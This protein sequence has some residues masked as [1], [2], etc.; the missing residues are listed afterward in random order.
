MRLKIVIPMIVALA[1]LGGCSKASA[2]APATQQQAT[3]T[4]KDGSTFSGSVTGNST[5]SISL[6]A[7]TGEART[8]PMSQVASVQ[9]GP[10]PA[11]PNQAA[12]TPPPSNP[13]P[14]NPAP[15]A[16]SPT[17][18]PVS[19]PLP[20]PPVQTAPPVQAAAPPSEPAPASAPPPPPAPVIVVR[21]IPAGTTISVRNNDVIDSATAQV[22]QAFSGVVCDRGHRR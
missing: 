12:A 19:E 16:A 10:A 6:Q 22:G 7:A 2:P 11:P 8:Y 14:S 15:Q 13:A 3:V 17:Q 21:T 1:A 4:L 20:A 18:A 5:D 9:Y